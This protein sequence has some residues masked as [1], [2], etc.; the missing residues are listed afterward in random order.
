[1]FIVV[2][3]CV[4][5]VRLTSPR[6]QCSRPLVDFGHRQSGTFV[7]IEF[8]IQNQGWRALQVRNVESDCG[9]VVSQFPEEPISRGESALV[10][11]RFLLK[12]IRGPQQRSLFVHTNESERHV[13]QFQIQ[14]FVD[15]IVQVEP[16]KV[17]V[18]ADSEWPRIALRA[19]GL[20]SPLQVTAVTCWPEELCKWK[21]IPGTEP[22]CCVIELASGRSGIAPSGGQLV[23][24]TNVPNE[25]KIFVPIQFAETGAI[26]QSARLDF[27][28]KSPLCGSLVSSR[29]RS[30][31]DGVVSVL[32]NAIGDGGVDC[33]DCIPRRRGSPLDGNHGL[34]GWWD[35]GVRREQLF[36]RM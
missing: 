23:I 11:V 31:H 14:G 9:C 33:F 10:S 29:W 17:L 15:S 18:S 28:M 26:P 22:N 2:V 16:A 34:I 13:H 27:N 12:H 35:T 24:T 3:C 5:T 21:V 8:E 7:D 4:G 6:L 1:M 25:E 20:V 36:L 30:Q 32:S 19:A